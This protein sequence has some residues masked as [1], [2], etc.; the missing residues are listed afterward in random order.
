MPGRRPKTV[1]PFTRAFGTLAEAVR[2]CIEWERT[3]ALPDAGLHHDADGERIQVK[4]QRRYYSDEELAEWL[5]AAS[6]HVGHAATRSEYAQ[7]RA[8]VI[9]NSPP[10]ELLA[11]PDEEIVYGRFGGWE[12]ALTKAGLSV[13]EW[14]ARRGRR[15]HLNQAVVD[16]VLEA[17]EATDGYL[18]DRRYLAWCEQA[19]EQDPLR[20][21]ASTG[22]ILRRIGSWYEI[23]KWASEVLAGTRPKELPA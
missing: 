13:E 15:V 9:R 3:G 4:P 22:S 19:R 12:N 1:T 23:R 21:I 11:V 16:C 7:F 8:H 20:C 17:Y 18:T 6:Q 14:K 2:A 10:G 5:K